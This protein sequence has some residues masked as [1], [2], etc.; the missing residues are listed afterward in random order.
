MKGSQLHVYKRKK[1]NLRRAGFELEGKSEVLHSLSPSD[2][3]KEN[4]SYLKSLS[5][6]TSTVKQALTPKNS[7]AREGFKKKKFLKT[8][9]KVNVEL[10]NLPNSNTE[11]GK[12]YRAFEIQRMKDIGKNL[13]PG[14]EGPELP[15]LEVVNMTFN[16]TNNTPVKYKAPRT[17][18]PT[19]KP[20]KTKLE[21]LVG[22]LKKRRSTVNFNNI[23]KSKVKSVETWREKSP[24]IPRRFGASKG[25]TLSHRRNLQ[26][27][28]LEL[29][30]QK[31]N[32][33]RPF[34]QHI[35]PQL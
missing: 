29:M 5:H 9:P 4:Q 30:K 10:I 19:K 1:K 27:A 13:F 16:T 20:D 34:T 28:N 15:D 14:E 32:H 8:T 25:S 35:L 2:Q 26:L 24:E 33:I 23:L 17:K 6:V 18:K 11:F 12:Q 3:R 7:T 21:F 31:Q 22:S